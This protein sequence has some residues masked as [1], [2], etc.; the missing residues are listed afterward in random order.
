MIF[1]DRNDDVNL[2]VQE[3]PQNPLRMGTQGSLKYYENRDLGSPI[4]GSLSSY[5]TGTYGKPT[6]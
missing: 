2:L 1:I 3:G 6:I 5:D 4:W